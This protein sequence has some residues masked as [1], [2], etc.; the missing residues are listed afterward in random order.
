MQRLMRFAHS[1]HLRH[2]WFVLCSSLATGNDRRQANT[3]LPP[4]IQCPKST[5]TQSTR[6][7]KA[8]INN[9]DRAPS[10][11]RGQVH[12][13]LTLPP[14]SPPKK[15]CAPVFVLAGNACA[16]ITRSGTALICTN[17]IRVQRQISCNTLC[18]GHCRGAVHVAASQRDQTVLP[19]R[20][21]VA[22]RFV[23]QQTP[24]GQT[25]PFI[26]SMRLRTRLYFLCTA[27]A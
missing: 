13:D 5:I 10:Y 11:R 19:T 25:P 6:R 12:C 26:R 23:G 22:A 17:H 14:D 7:T 21:E 4:L 15:K 18:T 1:L 27:V 2:P 3:P 20:Q 24:A 16:R 8:I 9:Q